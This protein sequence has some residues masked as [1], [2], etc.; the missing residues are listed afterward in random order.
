MG[1]LELASLPALI[2]VL[3]LGVGAI[4]ALTPARALST[5]GDAFGFDGA[6]ATRTAARRLPA[7]ALGLAIAGYGLFL[8]AHTIGLF[9]A[10]HL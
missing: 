4:L 9:R 7:R 1:L 8:T 2:A 10:F 5:L 3:L 6:A